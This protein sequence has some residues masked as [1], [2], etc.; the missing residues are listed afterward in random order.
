MLL[1]PGD[2]VWQILTD[3]PA[4]APSKFDYRPVAFS[5]RNLRIDLKEKDSR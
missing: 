5:L 1:E 3:L 2:T 4:A